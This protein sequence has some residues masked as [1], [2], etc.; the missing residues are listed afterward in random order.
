MTV[1][2]QAQEN[3]QEIGERIH[4]CLSIVMHQPEVEQIAQTIENILVERAR[5]MAGDEEA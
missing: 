1:Q 4:R 5:R 3:T 2:D